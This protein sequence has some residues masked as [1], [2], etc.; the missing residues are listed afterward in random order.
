MV[1]VTVTVWVFFE[2]EGT[3]KDR[4]LLILS[5]VMTCPTLV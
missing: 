4:T 5:L 1:K 2:L 3:M